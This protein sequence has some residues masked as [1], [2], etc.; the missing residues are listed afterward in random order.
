MLTNQT[1]TSCGDLT[2]TNGVLELAANASWLNGT[3]FTARGSG[4]L[5]FA[6]AKQVDK[7]IANLHFAESGKIYVP[8]GVTLKVA[9]ADVLEAG[10]GEPTQVALGTYDGTSGLLSGRIE[11]GGNVMVGPAG[12]YLFIK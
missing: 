9:A 10:A 5:K 12:L 2:A 6:A 8:A 11:G 4:L 1:F 7:K 3:N